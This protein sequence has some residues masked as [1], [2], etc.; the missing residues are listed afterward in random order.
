MEITL[1]LKENRATWAQLERL[2][3]R[4]HKHPNRVTAEEIDQ[5]TTLY[6]K[7]SSHLAF[8]RTYYPQD[9]TTLYLNQLTAQAHNVTFKQA[10]SSP[11]RLW[12][13]FQTYF[14]RLIEAR[15]GF[16]GIATLLFLLG[17]AFGFAS[18]YTDPLNLYAILPAEIAENVDPHRLGEGHDQ[19]N[20][21][22]ISTTI[23]VNNMQVAMLAFVSG[24]TFGLFTLYLLLYNGLIIGALAA[25]F[26]HAG[27]TYEFWAYILPHGIIE[28]TAIF[29]AGGAGLYMGY[30]MLVPGRFSRKHQLLQAAKES[31][32]LLLGTLPLFVIA[33]VIEGFVTPSALSLEVKYLFAGLTLLLLLA[34]YLY[35]TLRKSQSTSLDLSSR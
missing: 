1:F 30:R 10:Y 7:V 20:S 15:L 26:L 34:A 3:E 5:M 6:K 4:F 27:K 21:P 35:G 2:L 25:L 17:G 18:V 14:I 33:G 28:L 22:V 8:M 13:F 32:Q 24:I 31:A 23:M 19:I 16:I 9:E 12:Q 11:N 29:I